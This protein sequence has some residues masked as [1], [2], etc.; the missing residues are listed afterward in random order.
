[1]RPLKA[2]LKLSAYLLWCAV[3]IPPQI[4]VVLIAPDKGYILPQIFHKVTCRLFGLKCHVRGTPELDANPLFVSNHVSYLDIPVIGSVFQ[5]S[6]VAKKEVASWPLFGLLA[7]LQHT[8]FIDRSKNA[9]LES[10]N[11]VQPMIRE[12]RTLIVFPEG[13]SSD[14]SGILRFKSTLFEIFLTNKVK[15]Q[16]FTISLLAVDGKPVNAG[17]VRDHY[18][19]YGDI[20]LLPHL[21]TF[22]QTDGAEVLLTFHALRDAADYSDRKTLAEDCHKDVSAGLTDNLDTALDFQSKAA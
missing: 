1:M 14:G 12:G 2:V 8:A 15:I 16:P 5:G 10:K 3:M 4:L 19:W 7:K 6:F 17:G 9:V 20:D 11:A 18:A 21:W 22:A 13:T